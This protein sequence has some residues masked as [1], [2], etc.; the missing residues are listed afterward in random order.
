MSI[1]LLG[2]REGRV[3]LMALPLYAAAASLT[4]PFTP[5][6][7]VAVLIPG[8]VALVAAARRRPVTASGGV[9][10]G[11]RRA[12]LAWSTVLALAVTWELVAWL[13]QPAYNIASADHPSL[14][15]LLD[16]VTESSVP[17]FLVW[18]CWLYAGY[19]LVR[20]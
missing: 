10:P 16:P 19:R 17:R 3:A 4:Q 18:C 11:V 20:R 7:A 13:R 5:A 12:T 2:G 15:L 1:D 9:V 8:L 14:S 6:A